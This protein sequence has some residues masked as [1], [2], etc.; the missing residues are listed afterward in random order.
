V[1]SLLFQGNFCLTNYL[2]LG[3]A[4]GGFAGSLVKKISTPP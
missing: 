3:L 2:C 1:I 4:K